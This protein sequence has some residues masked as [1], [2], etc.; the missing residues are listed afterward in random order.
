M[1]SALTRLD[2]TRRDD[3]YWAGRLTLCSCEEDLPRYDRAFAAYF[4]DRPGDVA[5]ARRV[6]VPRLRLVVD[7]SGRAVGPEPD[8]GPEAARGQA[9]AAASTAERL[10]HRD[11]GT[12]G[13]AER[14]ELNRL[15][16][17]LRLPGERRPS[18][19]HRP[20]G[21]GGVDRRGTL[22]AWL[23]AGGEP[24]RIR[25]RRRADRPRRVVLLV[26]VSGSMDPYAD[27]LLRFAH[28]AARPGGPPTEV[29]T[30]GTR[31]SRVTREMRHRDPDAA[32]AAVAAA[33]PDSGGGT[34][35]GVL[36]KEFLDRWGQR[37]L[38]RGAVVVLLSDGWERD[39]PALLGLQVARLRRL[40]HRLVWA[41]PRKGAPGFTPAAAG[42]VA[43]L[44]HVDVFVTGHSLAAF[45][46]LA[47]VVLGRS[48]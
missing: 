43:A 10:R 39:D 6:L 2:A 27:A 7:E 18:R 40:A 32:M 48:R 44:P 34:R 4:G 33:T 24:A 26:D 28:A 15:L 20:A 11:V 23:A 36:L 17:A 5:R 22:R 12:L 47:D 25:H 42:V 37:G 3:V 31:L 41:N 30:L 45:E 29:F 35:L 13:A 46:N 16:A 21:H 9:V 1:L 14:A 19:R 8:D 38:A